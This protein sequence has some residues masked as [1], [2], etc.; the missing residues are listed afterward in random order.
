MLIHFGT[1]PDVRIFHTFSLANR[2]SGRLGLPTVTF[3]HMHWCSEPPKAREHVSR[4]RQGSGRLVRSKLFHW[5]QFS[6]WNSA[7]D[8]PQ[9]VSGTN[10]SFFR[11][12]R[13]NNYL[14]GCL[15]FQFSIHAFR[16]KVDGQACPEPPSLWG[17]GSQHRLPCFKKYKEGVDGPRTRC[18]GT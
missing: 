2:T 10:V 9:G 13:W 18:T 16:P 11:A 7:R 3:V 15:Q 6:D 5:P 14:I 12:I 17:G 8:F 4:T 1:R